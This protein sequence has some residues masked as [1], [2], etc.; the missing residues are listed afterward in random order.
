MS[1]AVLR[2]MSGDCIRQ[3]SGCQQEGPGILSLRVQ[4]GV[5]RVSDV[6][7]DSFISPENYNYGI[8]I[9]PKIP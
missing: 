1:A 4:R 5:V 7:K 9:E 6:S 8:D 3:Q 2:V